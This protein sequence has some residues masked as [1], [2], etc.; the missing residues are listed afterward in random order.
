MIFRPSTRLVYLAHW[1]PREKRTTA[2][3]CDIMVL[4]VT[5]CTLVKS[6]AVHSG[7]MQCMDSRICTFFL[8]PDFIASCPLVSNKQIKVTITK[9]SLF[10]LSISQFQLRPAPH[11]YPGLTP[12]NL[13]SYGWQIPRGR[14]HSSR[15]MLGS[16][17]E[18]RGQMPRPKTPQFLS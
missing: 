9:Y 6:G 4:F 17:E 8:N 15:Q 7:K 1:N 16:G 5:Q 10:I 11:P 2:R 3:R 14:G 12:R 13:Y 18:R